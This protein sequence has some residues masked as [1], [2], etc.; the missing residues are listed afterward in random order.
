MNRKY[1]HIQYMKNLKPCTG[2]EFFNFNSLENFKFGSVFF[3]LL[4]FLALFLQ[5]FFLFKEKLH[6]HQLAIFHFLAI[7]VF[8]KSYMILL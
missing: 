8:E 1:V 4:L 6:K 3:F 5:L 7:H 2:I